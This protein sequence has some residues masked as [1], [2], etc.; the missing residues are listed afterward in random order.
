[1][2]ANQ[3]AAFSIVLEMSFSR[4][5]VVEER[6]L[7]FDALENREPFLQREVPEPYIDLTIPRHNEERSIDYPLLHASNGLTITSVSWLKLFAK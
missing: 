2:Y 5:S 6:S 1:M 4:G 3:I 7:L